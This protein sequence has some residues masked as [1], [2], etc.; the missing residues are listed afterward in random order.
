MTV[1]LDVSVGISDV[2][3]FLEQNDHAAEKNV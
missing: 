3:W 1:Q 2:A